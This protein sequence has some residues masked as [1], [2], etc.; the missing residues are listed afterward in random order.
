[1]SSKRR[2]RQHQ[3]TRKRRFDTREDAEH[4][5]RAAQ[6]TIVGPVQM[7]VYRCNF[8]GGGFHFGHPKHGKMGRSSSNGSLWMLR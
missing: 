6:F 7:E 5:R 8:C 3:C 4:A 2:V 1:M